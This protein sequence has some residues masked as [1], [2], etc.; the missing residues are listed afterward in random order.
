MRTTKIRNTL[1]GLVGL[2]ALTIYILACT[3]FSPDDTK[4]LYPAFDAA[5]GCPGIAVYDRET[6]RSEMLLVP[7]RPGRDSMARSQWLPDGRQVLI[8]WTDK[9]D[10]LLNLAVVP[11]V[12]RG[13]VR[14][15]RLEGIEDAASALRFAPC[16]AGEQAFVVAASNRVVRLDLKSGKEESLEVAGVENRITLLPGADNKSLF[17]VEEDGGGNSDQ[18]VFGRLDPRTLKPT[19]IMSFTNK[20]KDETFFAYDASG[21][22]IAFVESADDLNRLVVLRDGKTFFT[23]PLGAKG[24]ELSF[25]SAG[26]SP[27]NDTIWATCAKRADA[28]KETVSWEWMEIPLSQAP[29]RETTLIASAPVPQDMMVLYFQGAVSHDGK[30]AAVASTYLACDNKPIKP[31]DCALFFI[32]LNDANRKVTRVPIPVPAKPE[33]Q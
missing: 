10:D 16:L 5:T 4:V 13:P 22:T 29:I 33:S 25:G 30:T 9:E 28:G 31:E 15:Y 17:Y 7:S 2:T 6:R 27:K 14:I 1:L 11:A 20:L 18:T 8:A 32:D 12:G 23:R 26:F 19:P 3:S 24:A 21:S